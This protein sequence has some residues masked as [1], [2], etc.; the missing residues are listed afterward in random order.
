M[1]IQGRVD[2]LIG[3]KSVNLGMCLRCRHLMIMRIEDSGLSRTNIKGG[4]I[5]GLGMNELLCCEQAGQIPVY[6]REA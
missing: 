4:V 5:S 2:Q 3:N 1:K 6:I